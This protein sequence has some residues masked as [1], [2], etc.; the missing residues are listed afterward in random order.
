MD[1][2]QDIRRGLEL[3]KETPSVLSECLE[4]SLTL[5]TDQLYNTN[6]HFF[7]EFVQNAEDNVYKNSA[8]LVPTLRIGVTDSVI[9]LS[10]NEVGF[11]EHNV[12]AICSVGKSTKKNI[13]GFI[14]EKGIGFKSVFKF[15]DI[16]H[17][18]SGPYTFKFDRKQRLGMIAPI[19]DTSYSSK[20]GWT[21]FHL[22]ISSRSARQIRPD[23]TFNDMISAVKPSLL[24]FLRKLR[25]IELEVNIKGKAISIDIE[26]ADIGMG[27]IQLT[28]TKNGFLQ[29]KDV[30]FIFAKTVDM[31]NVP[32]AARRGADSTEIVLAF[33]VDEY[34]QPRILPQDVHAFLPIRKFGF[35]FV[36]HGDFLTSSSREDILID[37]VWNA[38]IRKAIADTF[39]AAI[40]SF[41]TQ[42]S[43]S[44]KWIQYLPNGI[45]DPFFSPVE[46]SLLET[47]KEMPIVKD[48]D[49]VLRRPDEVLLIPSIYRYEGVPLIEE[50]F[51]EFWYLSNEYDPSMDIPVLKR[52]GVRKM[53]SEDFLSAI[54]N[55][56]TAY[57]SRRDN[58]WR[59]TICLELNR[60]YRYNPYQFRKHMSQT[61]F[62]PLDN[63]SWSRVC[64]ASKVVFGSD[65]S[66]IPDHLDFHRIHHRVHPSS[67]PRQY[68][69]YRALGV[70]EAGLTFV[71]EMI[72]DYKKPLSIQGHVSSA[73]F[74]FIN[75]LSWPQLPS[76]SRRLLV[77]DENGALCLGEMLYL[78]FPSDNGM[79]RRLLPFP[80]RFIHSAYI[81]KF[82]NHQSHDW[83]CWLRDELRLNTAPRI[84]NMRLSPEF[85][86]M[87]ITSSL[88]ETL[89]ALRYFWKRLPFSPR[90]EWVEELGQQIV[91]LEDGSECTLDSMYLKRGMLS[92]YRG[93]SFVPV[94][95][96]DSESWDFL[97][98]IGV[99]VTADVAF[100]IKLLIQ[101]ASQGCDQ[102]KEVIRIYK[103]LEARF[104]EDADRIIEA[105]HEHSLIYVPTAVKGPNWK[106]ISDVYWNGP[107]TM[108][109]KSA[110]RKLYPELGEFFQDKLELADAPPEILVD[111]LKILSEEWT[112]KCITN[113]V[114]KTISA[115]ILDVSSFLRLGR[116]DAS[117][118]KTLLQYA[119]F[120]AHHSERRIRLRELDDIYIPDYTGY[121]AKIFYGK[122]ELLELYDTESGLPRIKDL[123]QL[124][125]NDMVH[126]LDKCIDHEMDLHGSPI[127][128]DELTAQYCEMYTIF[129]RIVVD[130]NPRPNDRQLETLSKLREVRIFTVDGISSTLS[131][132]D[133]SPISTD[134]ELL[135]FREEE[136]SIAIFISKSVFDSFDTE[137]V[138]I[139]TVHHHISKHLAGMLNC[140]P[141]LLLLGATTP[142]E[143]FDKILKEKGIGSVISHP[144]LDA[145][146]EWTQTSSHQI[147]SRT[148]SSRPGRMLHRNN[149][150]QKTSNDNITSSISSQGDFSMKT[151]EATIDILMQSISGS[152]IFQQLVEVTASPTPL[153]QGLV[154]DV[155]RFIE[156]RYSVDKQLRIRGYAVNAPRSKDDVPNF[157]TPL[158]FDQK[159]NGFLGEQYVFRLLSAVIG[160][161]FGPGNW[162]SELRQYHP[163]FSAHTGSSLADFTYKD[164]VGIL[165]V[166][167]FKNDP[168][169]VAQWGGVLPTY[170]IEVK[171]TSSGSREPFFMSKRQMRLGLAMFDSYDKPAKD[172]ETH[173]YVLIRVWNVRNPSLISHA[174]YVD[175]LHCILN[176]S[177]KIV[178]EKL[179]LMV[180][181]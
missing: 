79:L 145:D 117:L 102:K 172:G 1:L 176:D 70:R 26:R 164:C 105:F 21:T 22:D 88:S 97:Y 39:I 10:C 166:H 125:P 19:W 157:S 141:E 100:F 114:H 133:V 82:V 108:T 96:P 46:E 142:R 103:Q 137:S 92:K 59:E 171:S 69:L 76:P 17:V 35:N 16:V 99:T 167:L 90:A 77:V 84:I 74:F 139:C 134:T 168:N 14:G 155:K 95:D 63:G 87:V 11:S 52:L 37:S 144:T 98:W 150:H 126:F 109:T 64:D 80:A 89:E 123:L 34:Q 131:L 107:A 148:I 5:L 57:L 163:G 170:H 151:L 120:P 9:T 15:A 4:H 115:M 118:A 160:S 129:E 93:I 149:T 104:D 43:L 165:T 128:N 41:Q 130:S 42:G 53:M 62:L 86:K 13:S 113:D 54:C 119:I 146:N 75:R 48:L 25:C 78:D 132:D 83:L 60:I 23:A 174:I 7:L 110:L 18:A 8:G 143:L 127:L 58:A 121:Y 156:D 67:S 40:P 91:V 140:S 44:N 24:L 159:V 68:E 161:T 49:G 178:S 173:V 106:S 6:T 153:L 28:R 33:P 61:R 31:S 3:D 66:A 72:L 29:D 111:E 27:F 30:Y 85:R 158:L 152:S 94:T 50:R 101:W 65:V 32:K 175:P 81:Q 36:I 45:V 51:M 135:H 56:D 181:E 38:S 47:L 138:A 71:A 169:T 177:L 179:E 2:I 12:R 180:G 147:S 122:V 112:D 73:S 162:T 136:S 154:G 55:M 124:A 116:L 20:P